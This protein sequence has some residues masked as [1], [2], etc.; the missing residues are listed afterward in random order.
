MDGS[1]R[2]R[3]TFVQFTQR[4]WSWGR[5]GAAT[6][7]QASA[8]LGASDTRLV[9][10]L[11]TRSACGPLTCEFLVRMSGFCALS[12]GYDG[13]AGRALLQAVSSSRLAVLVPATATWSGPRTRGR[14]R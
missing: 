7:D 6:A 14:S 8:Q 4:Y 1:A 12:R 3:Q 10:H 13:G 9:T 5:H 2:C 11:A